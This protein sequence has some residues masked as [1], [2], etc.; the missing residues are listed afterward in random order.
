MPMNYSGSVVYFNNCKNRPHE[1]LFG[2][3]AFY[4]LNTTGV[5]ASQ[6]TDI[7]VGQPCVVATS[8]DGDG[9]TFTWYS[10]LQERRRR[11]QGKDASRERFRVFYGDNLTAETMTKTAASSH[12][13]YNAFF[14]VK[15]HF[16]QQSTILAGVSADQLPA[17]LGLKQQFDEEMLA[18]FDRT[19]EAM[20]YWPR[21]F[22][23]KVK[24]VG[25]YQVAKD[26]LK[27]STKAATGFGRLAE[28]NRLDL[29]VEFMVLRPKW[30]PLFTDAERAV[31]RTRLEE[32]GFFT[33]PEEIPA[34]PGLIE[35][36]A[37][38]VQINAY[39]RNPKARVQCI[40][41]HKAVCAVCGFRF[42]AVYGTLAEK[43]I[44]V[45]HL[46]PLSAI[47]KKY[48]VDPINDLR[49][50]CPNCHAVIH[51][52]GECRSIEDARGMIDPRV[53]AFWASF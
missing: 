19:G 40:A 7:E 16:K 48:V 3:G 18:L 13:R 15:G 45:H 22:L 12:P 9:V 52:G 44:H 35:G 47:G 23:R 5:Q 4:D 24:K 10:F 50:V 6:A 2:P 41:H 21:Y 49:P 11:E 1:Q 20:G 32:A 38:T 26:L 36:A 51:M 8:A 46:K 27:P 37:Y 34:I 53:L 28:E 43:L 42:D 31:A 30:S 25:G 14:N 29:S 17:A 33:L 39:E